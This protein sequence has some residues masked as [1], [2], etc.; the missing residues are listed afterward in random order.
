MSRAGRA[1]WTVTAAPAVM[2]L[3]GALSVQSGAGIAARLFGQLPPAALTA[4][5]LWTAALIMLAVAGRPTGRAVAGLVGRRAWADG[6][7]ALSF[8]IVLGFMN[9]AIYQ[10]FARIPLG[11]AVTIEFLG[12]LS[13]SVAGAL[14]GGRGRAGSG[15]DS[16]GGAG[17]VRGGG[18]RA[19]GLGFAALAA[20]GVLLLAQ[21]AGGHL[22][23]AG[24]AWAVGA[25]LAW[26][27]YIVG[28]KAAGQRLP[29]ASGLVIAM[30]V[31]AAAVTAPGVAAGGARM[32]RPAFLAAGTAI[33][34]LSSVVPYWLELEALRRI[35][36]R[37]FGVWMSMQPAVAAL[38]GLA[39]LGQR[40]SAAEWAGICCVVAASAGAA[41]SAAQDVPSG[42]QG[43]AAV[44]AAGPLPDGSVKVVADGGV[45]E[46]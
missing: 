31:A 14:S 29:G 21:G 39:V 32:F 41:R 6:V 3:A 20:G 30:C 19:A 38:I 45:K 24:L 13:V 11:I 8:G 34:L 9:F 37:V 2:V 28:S 7:I 44:T 35:P 26:A 27:G 1:G 43:P 36:A 17:T 4:L 33:G 12:P 5:R 10:A 18:R 23:L 25:G 15:G 16:G 22:N 42:P 40:L 46:R